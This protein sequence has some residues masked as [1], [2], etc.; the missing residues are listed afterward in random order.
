MTKL[1]K[2][3]FEKFLPTYQRESYIEDNNRLVEINT[4]LRHDI[5]CLRAHIAGM[6]R[7]LKLARRVGNGAYKHDPKSE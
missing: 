5:E 7:G 3:L 2:W 6:E 4:A 1:K